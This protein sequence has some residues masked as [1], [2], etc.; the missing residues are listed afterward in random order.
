MIAETEQLLRNALGLPPIERAN[1]V[2]HLLSSL[3][4]PDEQIDDLWRQEVERRIAAYRKGEMRS[5]SLNE[6]L[7]KYLP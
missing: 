6:V 2:D 5:V 4:Q 3:D 7:A 1:L